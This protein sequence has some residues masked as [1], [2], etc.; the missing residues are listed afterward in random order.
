MFDA[1]ILAALL[2]FPPCYPERNDPDRIVR[3]GV[4]AE[5]IGRVSESRGLAS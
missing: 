2:A 4:L 3:L 5:A 1:A